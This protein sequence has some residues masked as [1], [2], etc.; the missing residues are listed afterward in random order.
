MGYTFAQKALARAAGLEHAEIGQIVDAR[1]D[2]TL[3]HDNTAA[4]ARL[5]RTLERGRVLHPERLAITLDRAR[6]FLRGQLRL[7]E[8]DK[9]SAGPPG[10][11]PARP[12]TRCG[13]R[14]PPEDGLRRYR[15]EHPYVPVS[16]RV[17]LGQMRRAF[18]VR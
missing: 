16:S 6:A 10:Q 17:T 4:I 5:Y 9:P 12:A 8:K 2:V 7:A 1:P 13:N 15:P 11:S 18:R 3:S 14:S